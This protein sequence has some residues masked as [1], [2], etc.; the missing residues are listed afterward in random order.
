MPGAWLIILRNGL[1][2]EGQKRLLTCY[3]Y[4]LLKLIR[5]YRSWGNIQKGQ[6]ESI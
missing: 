1:I 6:E 3:R 2:E 4:K 5:V